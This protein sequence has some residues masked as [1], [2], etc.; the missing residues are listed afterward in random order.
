MKLYNVKH[1]H[2]QCWKWDNSLVQIIFVIAEKINL[3]EKNIEK[4]TNIEDKV[5]NISLKEDFNDIYKDVYKLNDSEKNSKDI[6]D[7]EINSKN[8]SETLDVDDSFLDNQNIIKSAPEKVYKSNKEKFTFLQTQLSDNSLDNS[9]DVNNA[10]NEMVEPAQID[11]HDN[12][13]DSHIQENNKLTLNQESDSNI[14]DDS[15]IALENGITINT[16][17]SELQTSDVKSVQEITITVPPRRKKQQM[18]EKKTEI[19]NIKTHPELKKDYPVHLN[20]F[21]DDEDEV[22]SY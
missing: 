16:D 7:M 1:L 17:N 3:F 10:L 15:R 5:A 9:L 8:I 18:I 11:S 13:Q 2:I 6:E 12:T 21:S 4:D 19:N 14:T 20:P 22:S